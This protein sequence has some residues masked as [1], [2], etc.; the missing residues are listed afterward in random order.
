MAFEKWDQEA[1]EAKQEKE[2]QKR[3]EESKA[4]FEKAMKK[5]DEKGE[6]HPLKISWEEGAVILKRNGVEIK[7]LENFIAV[8]TKKVYKDKDK[9]IGEY[10]WEQYMYTLLG[11]EMLPAY[12]IH[13]QKDRLAYF[14]KVLGGSPKIYVR[15]LQAC[16]FKAFIPEDLQHVVHSF[17]RSGI[18]RDWHE[19][20]VTVVPA[21]ANTIR[22]MIKDGQS[23]IVPFALNTEK[24]EFNVS[25]FRKQV[26]KSVWKRLLLNSTTRN[27]LMC[28][29]ARNT[30]AKLPVTDFIDYPSTLLKNRQTSLG[31][32]PMEAINLMKKDRVMGKTSEHHK[33]VQTIKNT[34][35]MYNQLQK[36]LPKQSQ[37]WELDKWEERHNWCVEQINLKKYSKD[38]FKWMEGMHKT[39]TLETKQ[40]NTYTAEILDN[41]FAIR[42]EG[43]VM[44][45]CVGIY[46][47]RVADKKY[48]VVGIKDS[49]G[50]NYST[51][52]LHLNTKDGHATFNQHYKHYNQQVDDDS[53]RSFANWIILQINKQF[54]CEKFQSVYN[55]D[56][57]TKYVNN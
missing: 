36:E 27:G 14:Q 26:G 32:Y 22:Q 24:K 21:K 52:G 44:K 39:F 2:A 34:K 11:E 3:R 48:I 1:Y 37:K 5:L 46:G 55:Y 56:E 7:R 13:F 10:P 40:G 20:L 33:Y 6:I 42:T 23:N 51:L 50:K 4:V 15:E 16:M 17:C 25:E 45:H 43:E 49:G 35:D 29:T 28:E 30:R 38:P 57:D 19:R 9:H 31:T 53:V 47:G 12:E 54:A 41:V 18:K 8:K